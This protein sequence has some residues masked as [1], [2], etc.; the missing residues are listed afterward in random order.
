MLKFAIAAVCGLMVA[1]TAARAEVRPREGGVDVTTTVEI[2]APPERVWAELARPADWWNPQHSWSGSAANLS[3]EPRAG[4]CFCERL[5]EGGSA[6]HGQVIFA[7]PNRVLRIYGSLG[8][9][10]E[11][12]VAGA[13]TWKIEPAGQGSRVTLSYV[14][15]GLPPALA[16]QLA[17]V[18]D[19]VVAEQ[20]RRMERR[21]ETGR[22]EA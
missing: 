21:I 8:P 22:A 1:A 13:L 16:A 9:L 7:Q 6:Q 4:G 20:L 3:L 19:G 10:Q 12:G 14:F 5:A 17:P 2:A 15:G 11:L 18:V